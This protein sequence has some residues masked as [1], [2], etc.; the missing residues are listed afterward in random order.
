MSEE[1]G[2]HILAWIIV[3]ILWVMTGG[4]MTVHFVSFVLGATSAVLLGVGIF[5][6]PVGIVNALIFLFTGQSLNAY[7]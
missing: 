1:K 5:I 2:A 4:M 6:P 7:F 3:P